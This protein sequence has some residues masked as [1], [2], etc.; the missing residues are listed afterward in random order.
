[1]PGKHV[2]WL[3][4]ALEDM[5]S[6]LAWLEE[7]ADRETA[8]TV[9]QRIWDSAQSLCRLPSRGRP[10]RVPDTRELDV[11]NTAYFLV[12]RLKNSHVQILR[13]MHSSREYPDRQAVERSDPCL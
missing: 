7:E 11:A 5:D 1:M 12:H 9:A 2:R 8:H 13:V 3:K 6:L 4:L 10:G